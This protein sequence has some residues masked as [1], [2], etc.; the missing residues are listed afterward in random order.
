[1]AKRQEVVNGAS[2]AVETKFFDKTN[3]QWYSKEG[4]DKV[5]FCNSIEDLI[6]G[7]GETFTFTGKHLSLKTVAKAV[8]SDDKDKEFRKFFLFVLEDGSF[9]LANKWSEMR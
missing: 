2:E 7:K 9:I 4:T 1:M 8:P 5:T 3:Q 6:G